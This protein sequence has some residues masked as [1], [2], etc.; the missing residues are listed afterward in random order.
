[1]TKL[2]VGTGYLGLRVAERW[3][4]QGEEVYVTT[5]FSDRAARLSGDGFR[6]VVVDVTCPNTLNHLPR[7][8]TTLYAVGFDRGVG[9]TIHQVYVDGLA[10]TIN[11]LDGRAERF[12]YIS[13]SG[14]YGQEDGSWVDEHSDC[15]PLRPGGQACLEAER[16][17]AAHPLGQRT[18]ILRMAGIYGP[19]RVPRRD[20]LSQG[21]PI[22]AV[23]DSYLNLIHVD[24]AVEAIMAV[25]QASQLPELYVVSDGHPVQRGEYF[26][27]IARRMGLSEVTIQPPV[28]VDRHSRRSRGDKRLDNRKLCRQLQFSPRYPSFIEGLASILADPSA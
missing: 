2:V 9:N 20:E 27:E 11:A 10:N 19:D 24:D 14:V 17:L 4:N 7:V 15:K 12:V 13:S 21:Q 8:D 5:R 1:V 26:A 18:V 16:R 6:A 22:T 3:R 23:A 25:E 28:E